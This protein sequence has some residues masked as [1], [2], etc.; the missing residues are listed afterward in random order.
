MPTPAPFRPHLPTGTVTFLFTDI[1][2]ST[3]LWEQ[4]PVAMEQAL[5]RHDTLLRQAVEANQGYVFKTVG[6][7]FC[8]A[9]PTAVG[10]LAATLSLHR[11]LHAEEWGDTGPLKVRAGLHTGIAQ[12]R[13]GDYFGPTLNRVARLQA[14]GHGGQTLLST[15]TYELVRD[16]LPAGVQLLGLGEHRLK[17]LLRPE[18]VYQLFTPDLP[19]AFPALKTLDTQ[20]NN[21]PR[22]TTDFIGRE[23]EVAAVSVLV[24]RA[25]SSLVTLTGPGG[26]GKTRLGLQVAVELMDDFPDGVWFVE[27]STIIEPKLVVPTIAQTLGVKEAVGQPM[28]DTLKVH[29]KDKHLLLVLDNFEQVGEA[30]GEVSQLLAASA[31]LKVLATSRVPL[32]LRG[33]KEYAV[34]PLELPDI[35][36]LPQLERLTQYGAVRLFIERAT[37]VKADFEVTNENAPSVAEICVRLDGLPLAI[38]L[39]AARIRMLPPHSLLSKLS[40]R[41]KFLTGGARD[42]PARQQ[43]LRGAIAWSYEL[44]DEGHKEFFRRMS[45]FVGGRSL[46]ALEAVCNYDGD[47]QVDVF[48]GVE[49]LLSS[50]LIQQREGSE[51]EPRFVMLETIHEYAREKLHDSGEGQ[52]LHREHSLYFMKLAEEAESQLTGARQVEWL[53]RLEYEH[54]NMRAALRW[55]RESNQAEVGLRLAGALSQ[56][57][58][59]RGYL[60]EGRE[61]LAGVL[62]LEGAGSSIAMATRALSAAKAKAL[63]GAG[64]LAWNQGDYGSTRLLHEQGLD[65]SRELEDRAGMALSL[66]YLGRVAQTEGNHVSVQPLFE[67]SLAISRD[68]GDKRGSAM[69]LMYLGIEAFMQGDYA[70][71][72]PLYEE[73]LG[74]F[75]EVGDNWVGA[76]AIFN[77]GQV[78][79]REGDDKRAEELYA[80]ALSIFR[81]V[82]D[83]RQLASALWGFGGAAGTSGRPE[84]GARLLGAAEALREVIGSVLE[85]EDQIEYD[86]DVSIIRDQMSQEACAKAWA[87]GRAMSMEQAIEY[88]LEAV[89]DE[90]ERE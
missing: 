7:A 60:S 13:D 22:Q 23:K 10:A 18:G 67:E 51:G 25:G 64:N 78:A 80:Q 74:L 86:R 44:L 75:G 53:A 81:E 69:A 87:E 40:Q 76:V 2:G 11:A 72:R 71:A 14:A 85:P 47:L 28:I 21:L 6:D 42:L 5:Q 56:F 63:S 50:S 59:M 37:D 73:S 12:E 16:H 82:G 58:N 1:E 66:S 46:E 43:T 65:M 34:S 79:H 3:K 88:A 36:Q 68:L 55:A 70:A 62:A 39:A 83:R 90:H 45:P 4:Y 48:E 31:G 32:R 54:D 35:K 52:A 41:L 61:Q 27:L 84:R 33:E 26:T 15:P 20:P 38:E 77:I 49:T 89:G 30:A 9:F 57:W 8:A 29:L 24:R 19:A 17:D